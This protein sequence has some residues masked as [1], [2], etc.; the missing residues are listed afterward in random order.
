MGRVAW[1]PHRNSH[2]FINFKH[3]NLQ[4]SITVLKSLNIGVLHSAIAEGRGMAVEWWF[5]A[6]GSGGRGVGDFCHTAAGLGFLA[7]DWPDRTIGL[8]PDRT[9]LICKQSGPKF[10]D[11]TVV[12][13][14]GPVQ[15]KLS[16]GPVYIFWTGL[17][18]VYKKFGTGL[19]TVRSFIL[20]LNIS[21]QS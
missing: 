12:R 15:S 1:K 10:W 14:H 11:R 20:R 9:G 17:F 7:I 19:L 13:S 6:E 5:S 21:V 16:N 4:V 8:G 3:S 18:T 2:F